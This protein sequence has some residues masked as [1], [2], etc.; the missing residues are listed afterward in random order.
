MSKKGYA[1]TFAPSPRR[2]VKRMN[3]KNSKE[4]AAN[5]IFMLAPAFNTCCTHLYIPVRKWY[6]RYGQNRCV[7]I[8]DR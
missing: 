4:I 2:I 8:L 5:I 6:P 1:Q 7:Q 3:M